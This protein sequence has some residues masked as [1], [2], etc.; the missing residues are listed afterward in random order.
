MA[1]RRTRAIVTLALAGLSTMGGAAD[2]ASAPPLRGPAPNFALTTQQN[3]RLW[4]TQLRGRA[5]VLAFGC[6]A[7]GAC[8]ELV[9]GLAAIARGLGD[10]PGRRVFF[11][12][13]TVDPVRDTPAVLREF[14]RLRGLR[15]PA[16]LFL[17]ED[18]SGQVQVVTRRYGIEVRRAGEVI[19]ADCVATLIDGDGRIRA[20]Y[21]V[22]SLG[23]LD[24][25]LRGLLGLPASP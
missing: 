21:D 15:A 2:R 12:L 19:E 10:A 25:D 23:Q 22:A 18:R 4:L 13:V 8:P 9:P 24:R 20:R 1:R 17:T 11:A 7:C 14:G 6:A 5:V 16:W 3:D